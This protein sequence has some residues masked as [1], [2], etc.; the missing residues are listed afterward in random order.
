MNVTNFDR[1]EGSASQLLDVLAL[2]V[3]NDRQIIMIYVS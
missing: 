3:I 2:I 1:N